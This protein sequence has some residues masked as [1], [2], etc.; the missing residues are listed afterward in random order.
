MNFLLYML[1]RAHRSTSARAM[2]RQLLLAEAAA[3]A[4][5][6]ANGGLQRSL[7]CY[8]RLARTSR[9]TPIDLLIRGHLHL[10]L[11]H[12]SA[13]HHDLSRGLDRLLSRRA[14]GPDGD[15]GASAE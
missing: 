8:R 6:A 2:P 3:H 10:V 5:R 9:L 14:D 13:A 1:G 12:R 7:A 4:S 11:D 15:K